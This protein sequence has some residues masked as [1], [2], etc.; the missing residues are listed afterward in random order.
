MR[1]GIST[2]GRR[3]HVQQQR[4]VKA[5]APGAGGHA[6]FTLLEVLAG[7]A[8]FGLILA[9][10]TSGVRFGQE[11]L[12]TQSRSTSV[13]NDIAPVDAVLRSL[14]ARAWPGGA[15]SAGGADARFTGT[16][17]TL[18][19]RTVL[20]MS[21]VRDPGRSAS[22][23]LRTRDAAVSIGV[24]STHRLYLTWLPW[25]RRWLDVKP[26]PQ[27]VEMLSGLDHIEFAYWDPSLNLPPGGWVTGWVGMTAPKLLRIR[28]I[29]EK[30]TGM[31][32][33]DIIVA[34]ERE[35]LVY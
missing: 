29:F 16:A 5:R 20:P 15:G 24:D 25:Y 27:R 32:W 23:W 18:S 26:R 13:V 14:I 12:K 17:R 35:P 22:G 33:P 21:V 8:I 9:G 2:A 6:G 30:D 31:H 1:P 28:M 10:L 11:A 4:R 3:R 7:L 34:T 19:F